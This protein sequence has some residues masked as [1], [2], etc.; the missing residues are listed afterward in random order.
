M[1]LIAPAPQCRKPLF[2]AGVVRGELILRWGVNY[3]CPITGRINL[4]RLLRGCGIRDLKLDLRALRGAHT[5][6]VLQSV[7]AHPQLVVPLRQIR[8]EE[9]SLMFSDAVFSSWHR[10]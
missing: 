3:R 5:F 4:R 8:H 7:A 2:L 1:A 9:A 10:A 6:G